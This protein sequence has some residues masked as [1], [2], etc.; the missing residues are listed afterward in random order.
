MKFKAQALAIVFIIVGAALV[1]AYTMNVTTAE[2]SHGAGMAQQGT[3]KSTPTAIDQTMPPGHPAISGNPASGDSRFSHFRVG[4][5]NV[6]SIYTEGDIVWIGTSGGVIRYD[7]RHDHYDLFDNKV[8][9]ILSNGVF[10]VGR[11]AGR[12]IVGTYGGGMSMY[13]PEAH[14]WKNYNI[15][16][17]LADQ[18]VYDVVEAGNGDVWIATWSGINRVRGG[19]FDDPSSWDLFTMENT[20]GGIPNPWVY[21][22]AEGVDGVMWFGTEEGLARYKDGQWTHW[23]HDDGLGAPY[24]DVKESIRL[25]SDPARLSRHHAR[26]KVDQGL[27]RVKGAYNPNYIIS[28]AVDKKGTVWCG[29]WGAGLARFDGKKW[30]NFTTA[31]GLPANHI[32]MLHFDDR[33]RLWIGT[34]QGLARLNEDGHSFTVLTMK[35][36]LYAD[37]VFSMAEAGDG[38]VWIG[39]FGGV[40][41]IRSAAF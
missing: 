8:K 27:T 39:S 19:K 7:V 14:S 34:N 32:F 30:K 9:G 38:S 11:A 22:I 21:G 31:D 6:K 25:N 2:N 37:N 17:G 33:G 5:R 20:N 41:H 26:Q 15:P 1:L 24:D 23:K 36:G 35:D 29:T 3:A 16:D 40:A 4:N 18:F 12:L 28:L 13:D 10:H